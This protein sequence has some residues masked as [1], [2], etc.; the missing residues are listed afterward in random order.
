MHPMVGISIFF[1]R[2]IFV[3][4]G[5][6]QYKPYLSS[7]RAYLRATAFVPL[8]NNPRIEEVRFY[9]SVQKERYRNIQ[10]SIVSSGSNFVWSLFPVG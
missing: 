4:T 1:R 7:D 5:Q 9:V 6:T 2:V 10:K 3:I 8:T